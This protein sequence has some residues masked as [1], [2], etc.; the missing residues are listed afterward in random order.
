MGISEAGY[1][2]NLPVEAMS[3]GRYICYLSISVK[4]LV[5]SHTTLLIELAGMQHLSHFCSVQPCK[6]G[7]SEV[8]V[9]MCLQ[10][11]PC[12]KTA[13]FGRWT[14]YCSLH[15]QPTAPQHFSLRPSSNGCNRSKGSLAR[16]SLQM[17]WTSL[18]DTDAVC[19]L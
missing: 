15:T 9:W 6:T 3:A 4:V 5:A 8:R 19:A 2:Q 7:A 10:L 14:M 16:T 18:K 13:R 12:Q 17:L 11:S 1:L